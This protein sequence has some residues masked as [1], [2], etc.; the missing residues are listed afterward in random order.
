MINDIISS[1][2]MI[3]VS[4]IPVRPYISPGAYSAGMV[5]Y[6]NSQL[7]VYDGNY[8]QLLSSG[9][10]YV[11]LSPIAEEAIAWAVQQKQEQQRIHEL[12][13]K[14]PGLKAAYEQFE[15]MKILVTQE[16]K[17]EK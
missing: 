14:H 9:S 8:W 11:G 7:E 12:M 6:H 16:H 13:Q 3:H 2:P 10:T 1:S 4:G 17:E 15:I 5:R